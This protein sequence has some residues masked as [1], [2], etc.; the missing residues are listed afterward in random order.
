M[1][2]SG[3]HM[4]VTYTGHKRFDITFDKSAAYTTRNPQNQGDINKLFGFSDC[5]SQH[6]VN[7]ARFGWRWYKNNLEIHAYTYQNKVRSA[8]YIGNVVIGKA[9][10]FELRVDKASYVFILDGKRVI[11]PRACSGIPAGYLLYPYFGG[12]E[13]APHDIHIKFRRL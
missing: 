3:A 6:Q 10:R 5:G 11:L 8:V 12:D 7:S 1:H 2:A 9:S 13:P 4:K